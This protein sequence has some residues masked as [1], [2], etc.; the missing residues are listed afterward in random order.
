[1][2]ELRIP[3]SQIFTRVTQLIASTS[4]LFARI[5]E[6]TYKTMTL[7]TQMAELRAWKSAFFGMILAIN[8]PGL[9]FN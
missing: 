3:V 2:T 8:T 5:F 7:C 4:M 9:I 1:M 6:K